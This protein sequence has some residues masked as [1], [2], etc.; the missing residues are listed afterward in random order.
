MWLAERSIWSGSPSVCNKTRVEGGIS[1]DG[2]WLSGGGPNTVFMHRFKPTT[3]STQ[4]R[5]S[6]REKARNR[7]QSSQTLNN[8]YLHTAVTTFPN[9]KPYHKP[10][11]KQQSPS[12]TT[13][14]NERIPVTYRTNFYVIPSF[15]RRRLSSSTRQKSLNRNPVPSD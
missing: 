8:I 11:M 14:P 6:I 9:L 1:H 10:N 3:L 5:P 4:C 13:S 7:G 12:P 2:A 15:R